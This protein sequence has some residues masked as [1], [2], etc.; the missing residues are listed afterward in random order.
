[1]QQDTSLGS[2]DFTYSEGGGEFQLPPPGVYK[3][4]YKGVVERNGEPVTFERQKT[5][6][7]SKELLYDDAGNPVMDIAVQHQFAIDDEEDDYDGV[8]FRDIFPKLITTGNKSGWL[9]AAFLDKSPQEVVDDVREKRI[10]NTSVIRDRRCEATLEH[11]VSAGNGKTYIK[12]KA[13]APLRKKRGRSAPPAE[14]VPS[15]P[16]F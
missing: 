12:I 4:V 16:N 11:S 10:T 2:M 14:G 8:E 9:W 5:V 3:I 7:N 13:A 1:M 6:Y 15:E